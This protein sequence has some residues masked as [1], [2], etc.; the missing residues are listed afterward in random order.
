MHVRFSSISVKP[1]KTTMTL[2][3]PGAVMANAGIAWL[4]EGVGT[5]GPG[6]VFFLCANRHVNYSGIGPELVAP[7]S[8]IATDLV[9]A[10]RSG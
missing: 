4:G 9:S 6:I 1:K 10:V 3:T 8:W 2:L 5:C 7:S